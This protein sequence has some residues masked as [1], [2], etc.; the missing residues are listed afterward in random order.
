MKVLFVGL[1]GIGQRHLRLLKEIKGQKLDAHAYRHRNLQFLLSKNL[2]I[3][4][5]T[6]LIDE[7]GLSVHETLDRALNEKPDVVFITNPT[8]EHFETAIASLN[9]GVPIFVEK[10]IT[11]NVSEARTLVNLA[12]SRSLKGMVGYQLRFHPLIQRLFS[13]VKDGQ[14]GDVVS[15]RFQ[16]GEYLPNWHR[17]ED[18]RQMYAAR[19][20]L[21]GGV[22]RTQIHEIDL[23]YAMF[24]KPSTAYSVGGKLSNLERDVEDVVFSLFQFGLNGK[25]VPMS[26]SQDY[27]QRPSR[28]SIE[29]VG[30]MGRVEL[31][32]INNQLLHYSENGGLVFEEKIEN[33]DRDLMFLGQINALLE[34]LHDGN[35]PPVS[36]ADGLASLEIADACLRSMNSGEVE[37]VSS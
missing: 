17:Y 5:D 31:D 24:G 36:L 32:L 12:G 26:L 25:N 9:A 6:G 19:R 16:V 30:L 34:Y 27:I 37:K 22:V 2:E 28:R 7:F 18:Y 8:S 21:G 23:M 29:V 1:G 20:D 33:F 4:S 14:L 3:S 13:I 15:A 10:P 11:T 35:P